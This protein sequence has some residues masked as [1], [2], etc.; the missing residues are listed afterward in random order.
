[1]NGE[2]LEPNN[3]MIPFRDLLYDSNKK[4]WNCSI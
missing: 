2:V 1:M 3:V 4:D